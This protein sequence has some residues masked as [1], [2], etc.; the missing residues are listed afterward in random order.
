MSAMFLLKERTITAQY[1]RKALPA[2]VYS[3]SP[4]NDGILLRT[5]PAKLR[6]LMYYLSRC[7]ALQLKTLADIAAVDRLRSNA[8]FSIN[9]LL[10]SAIMNQRLVVQVYGNETATIPSLAVPFANGQRLFASAG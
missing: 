5:T 9:Y 3:A 7:P 4:Q 1:L 2:L 6:A 10:F 8:R